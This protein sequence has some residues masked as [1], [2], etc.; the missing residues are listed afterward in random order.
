M[1]EK[2]KRMIHTVY[3]AVSSLLIVLVGVCLAVSCVTIYKSGAS[4]FTRVSIAEQFSK[5]A[6]PVWICVTAVIGGIVLMLALPTEGG[7]LRG[8]VD[9]KK[10]LA[11]LRDRIDFSV[12][13]PVVKRRLKQ[14]RIIRIG[15]RIEGTLL[16][17][18]A[19]M[20]ALGYLLNFK[21]FT[22]ENLNGDVLA[23]VLS[24]VPFV[25][26]AT[27]CGFMT[28]LLDAESVNFELSFVKKVIAAGA[29]RKTVG[30]PE[31]TVADRG[32]ALLIA[33]VVVIAVALIFIA[34]GIF[35]GGMRDVLGKAIKICTECIGLG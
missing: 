17:L 9:R 26:V 33:R 21:H 35:N 25:I 1:N 3:G 10:T 16:S 30:D 20:P 22:V 23:G 11:K 32:R 15:L 12:C 31:S 19:A 18:A 14:E 8:C 2:T 27:G 28:V 6:V 4:P 24:V 5:I 7:K 34:V 29:V 13:A